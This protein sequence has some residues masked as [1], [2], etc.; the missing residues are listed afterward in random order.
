METKCWYNK[1]CNKNCM[2]KFQPIQRMTTEEI[3][4]NVDLTGTL[5]ECESKE[6]CKRKS[7]IKC[8]CPVLSKEETK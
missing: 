3:C 5:V 4:T 1:N 8:L 2:I 7:G 6:D